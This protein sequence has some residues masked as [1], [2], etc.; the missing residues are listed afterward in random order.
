MDVP[1][2]QTAAAIQALQ[3]AGLRVRLCTRYSAAENALR[4]GDIS[5]PALSDCAAALRIGPA[6]APFAPL[7]PALRALRIFTDNNGEPRP[8]PA[9][10][11]IALAS[12]FDGTLYFHTQ[13]EGLR[14]PDMEAVRRFRSAGGLF[15]I[16]TGRS[17]HSILSELKG[18]TDIDFCIC[19]SG[20][21]LLDGQGQVLEIHP[22]ARETARQLH[23]RY[24][25]QTWGIVFHD[26]WDVYA[27]EN[28]LPWQKPA[29]GVDSIPR[30]IL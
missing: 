3:A 14:A 7:P 20:G 6:G 16:S 17:V 28:R 1:Q 27:I 18:H 4:D 11:R 5:V 12:D 2:K 24:V 19:A 30:D 25:K 8:G 23:D 13:P 22:L 26:G 29:D 10:V 21:L 9:P 15:G